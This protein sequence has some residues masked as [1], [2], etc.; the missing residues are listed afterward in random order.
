MRTI[1]EMKFGSY[2]YG[3][4]TPA[5]DVDYKSVFIPDADSIL[6]QRAPATVTDK[7]E[8]QPFEKNVA[9]DIDRES[10]ALH[11][12]LQLLSEGQ[13]VALDMLFAP[14]WTWTCEQDPI[15]LKIWE[16]R[17]KFLSRRAASFIGYCRT[18][19]NKYGIKGSRVHAVRNIVAWFDAAIAIHGH[20][21]KLG[22]AADGLPAFIDEQKLEHTSIVYIPYPGRPEPMPHL[23]CCNRKAP[24]STSLKDTR[25]IYA[26]LL[27]EYGNRSLQAERNE[28]VD[29]KALSHAVRVGREAMELLTTNHITFPLPYAQH[30]LAI[31]TGQLPYAIVAEEIESLLE[32]VETAEKVS[33]LRE[34][35]DMMA[36][37]DI[38]K[39]AYRAEV[40]NL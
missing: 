27:D 33:L 24:F 14:V 30:I 32:K 36:I 21:A 34:T 29:W 13:T 28:N 7:R 38:V 2:L 31:K 10:Y 12:Y 26:R 20:L 37:E 6:L 18:Q 11:R 35:P 3:T 19:A 5:S 4:M 9:G 40:V 23:E 16:N 22:T 1:V 25:A 15:W 39:D 17:H 8:K